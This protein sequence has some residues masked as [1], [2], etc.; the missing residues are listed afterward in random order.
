MRLDNIEALKVRNRDARAARYIAMK[1][2]DKAIKSTHRA[3]ITVSF[4][5]GLAVAV[6]VMGYHMYVAGNL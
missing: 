4:V 2:H 1:A 5:A 6:L 3:D